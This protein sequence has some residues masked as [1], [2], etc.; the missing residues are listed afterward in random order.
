MLY[1]LAFQRFIAASV[2]I[3]ILVCQW[4]NQAAE[5]GT[6]SRALQASGAKQLHQNIYWLINTEVSMIEITE[7]TNSSVL[8][9]FFAVFVVDLFRYQ[10]NSIPLHF[11]FGSVRPSPKEIRVE[12]DA[13]CFC[14][15]KP[16]TQV[17]RCSQL[18]LWC[19]CDCDDRA[20]SCNIVRV[21]V[22]NYCD[23]DRDATAVWLQPETNMFI[24]LRG[25][26]QSQHRNPYGRGRP[27]MASL[28][29]VIFTCFG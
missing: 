26:I 1:N 19:D 15:R 4:R 16:R 21:R 29:T 20:T 12:V 22:H 11:I 23:V 8:L 10:L 24:F 18:R 13:I 9:Q 7:W 5:R 3:K 17:K 14:A 25:C 2:L 28:F 6:C 27:A